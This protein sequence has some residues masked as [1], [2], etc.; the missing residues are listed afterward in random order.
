MP[1]RTHAPRP[2]QCS[3]KTA[4]GAIQRLPESRPFAPAPDRPR[5]LPGDVLQKME[6]AFGH[7]FSRVRIHEGE[8]AS[9]IGARAFAQGENLHFAPGAF[10]PHTAEGQKVLG[11]ELA[12]VVQQRQRLVRPTARIGR[13]PLNADAG[14]EAHAGRAGELAARGVSVSARGPAGDVGPASESG[15]VVQGW[16]DDPWQ[17]AAGVAGGLGLAYAAARYFMP[18][19]E[20]ALRIPIKTD[21][22]YSDFKNTV[23]GSVGNRNPKVRWNDRDRTMD[24]DY[25]GQQLFEQVPDLG[26]HMAGF[27]SRRPL[28][29]SLGSLEG[30]F[31]SA[32]LRARRTQEQQSLLA[33]TAAATKAFNYAGADAARTKS[34]IRRERDVL[35]NATTPTEGLTRVLASNPG[36]V[37]GEDHGSH[38][39]KAYLATHMPTLAASGVNTVYLEHLRPDHQQHVDQYLASPRATMHPELDRFLTTFDTKH[40]ARGPGSVR[41]I[42]A[43]ARQSG[44]RV[45]AADTLAADDPGNAGQDG[46]AVRL[47]TMNQFAMEQV[48]SDRGR[49]GGKYVMLVGGAH[50]NTQPGNA[51]AQSLG[52]N[53]SV[54]GLSQML[55]IP[56]VKVDPATG[57]PRLDKENRGHR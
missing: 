37:F 13:H 46:L 10:R 14:L 18:R 2:I 26:Y 44:V 52:I 3:V 49:R 48:Q 16:F 9:S 25:D 17:V 36:M 54:P 1:T 7:D 8:R 21:R 47:A 50:N 39:N 34:R 45:R 4:D 41:G 56:A 15:G 31:G 29:G 6:G 33:R 38:E 43:A 32:G 27:A 42:L 19:R 53:G 20:P 22:Q 30:T 11:H 35:A 12:H 28:D 5:T 24:S 23:Q 51:Y 40:N 57:Q 55:N